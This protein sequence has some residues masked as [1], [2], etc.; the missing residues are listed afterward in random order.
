MG[1]A[2]V[3]GAGTAAGALATP[4]IAQGAREMVIVSTWPR[5]APGVG[6]SAQRLANRITEVSEGKIQTTYYAAGEKVGAFDA[7]DEVA[8]GNSHAYN[9]AEYYWKGKHAGFPFFTTV[10]FGMTYPER[11]AWLR[12]GGGQELWDE[13]S[14]EFGLKALPAGSTGC[15]MGGWFNREINTVDDLKGL[16]FR[17]VGIGGDVLTKLGVSVVSLPG[18]QIY[19]NLVSGAIDAVEWVGPWNDYFLKFYEAA[20]FYYHPGFHE[21]GGNISLGMNKAWWDGLTD[22][23]RTVIEVCCNEEHGLQMDETNWNNGIYLRKMIAENGVELREFNDE[24]FEA[25]GEASAE[26]YEELRAHSPL[27]AKIVEEWDTA[28]R[29]VGGY[30]AIADVAFAQLRNRALGIGG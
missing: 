27:A 20:K 3:L 1:G 14:A 21:P 5:D 4:A 25:F 16:K 19:E 6:T 28:L 12:F 26:V 10:P 13:L 22:W 23:E 24:V 17:T 9:G 30:M 11:S 8:S 2:A 29:Q 18:G 7:F 15:Q